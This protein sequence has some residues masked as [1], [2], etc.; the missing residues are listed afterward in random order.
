MEIIAILVVLLFIFAF[1][2]LFPTILFLSDERKKKKSDTLVKYSVVSIF[3]VLLVAVFAIF[4]ESNAIVADT[5]CN[6]VANFNCLFS[7]ILPKRIN[8]SLHIYFVFII[9]IITMF[10]YSYYTA[11]KV[12]HYTNKE[13]ALLQILIFFMVGLVSTIVHYYVLFDVVFVD[14]LEYISL[15]S[16]NQYGL[17]PL[18]YLFIMTYLNRD[19]LKFK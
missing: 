8:P 17:L 13:R 5:E 11:K 14:G 18:M 4:Y 6:F 7:G 16:A 15:I 10:T 2:L 19:Q 9:Q 1:G 3:F 12:M